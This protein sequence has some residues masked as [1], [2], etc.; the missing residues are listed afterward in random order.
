M[1]A[2]CRNPT[3]SWGSDFRFKR[4]V[5]NIKRT[6]PTLTPKIRPSAS[7]M[8]SSNFNA[9]A[10]IH[11][12][13]WYVDMLASSKTQQSVCPGPLAVTVFSVDV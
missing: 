7:S 13:I 6:K 10:T 2:E 5:Y 11:W 9:S 1:Q 12:P 3:V 4:D 8:T